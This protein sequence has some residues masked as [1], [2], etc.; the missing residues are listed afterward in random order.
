MHADGAGDTL[1]AVLAEVGIPVDEINHIFVNARLLASRNRTASFYGYSQSGSDL[2]EWDLSIP[3]QG[4]DRIGLFG[5]DM[6]ILGM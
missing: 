4:G 2:S 6:S 5:E 3:V 1:E